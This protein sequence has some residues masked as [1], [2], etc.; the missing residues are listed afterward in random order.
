MRIRPIIAFYLIVIALFTFDSLVWQRYKKVNELSSL[1]K[2]SSLQLANIYNSDAVNPLSRT[3]RAKVDFADE[4]LKIYAGSWPIRNHLINQIFLK[5]ICSI[6][7]PI[8][9]LLVLWLDIRA[10]N[11]KKE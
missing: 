9:M 4:Q 6:L 5:I 1:I 3:L 7:I 8:I 2:S 10:G 11:K